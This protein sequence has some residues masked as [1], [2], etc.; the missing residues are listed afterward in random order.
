[1]RLERCAPSGLTITG[2]FPDVFLIA[3]VFYP[4]YKLTG[5]QDLLESYFALLDLED[6]P[7]YDV[8]AIVLKVRR[9]LDEL[10][11]HYSSLEGGSVDAPLPPSRSSS[12]HKGK[13]IFAS[14]I[15]C[16]KRVRTSGSGGSSMSSSG[17]ELDKYLTT[18]HEFS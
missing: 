7:L 3:F 16:S 4:K 2:L 15:F 1:M 10:F 12:T 14:A 17:S 11:N 18:Y 8:D 9:T 6:N 5:L 13:S